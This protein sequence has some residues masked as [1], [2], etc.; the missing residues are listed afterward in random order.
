MSERRAASAVAGPAMAM[1]AAAASA[2]AP[3]ARKQARAI[4]RK[5][6]SGNAPAI[7]WL[8]ASRMRDALL[9]GD[10]VSGRHQLGPRR[11]GRATRR[12]GKVALAR[13]GRIEH[14]ARRADDDG[15]RRGV[16]I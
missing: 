10:A 11:L 7:L 15:S 9:R 2:V 5:A 12:G 6:D 4:R 1:I 13:V 16:A 8:L 14:G 3:A